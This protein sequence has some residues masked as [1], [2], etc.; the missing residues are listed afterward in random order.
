MSLWFR[1][2]VG[3]EL[4]ISCFSFSVPATDDDL[5]KETITTMMKDGIL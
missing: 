3:F 5:F 2:S 1:Y 4:F